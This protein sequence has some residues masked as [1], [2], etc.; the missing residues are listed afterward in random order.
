MILSLSLIAA[1]MGGV[2]AWVH[3]LTA[4]PI[5]DAALKAKTD[6]LESVLPEFDNNPLTEAKEVTVDGDSAP[7]T[8]YMAS[9]EGAPSGYAVESYTMDGFSGEIRVMVGFDKAGAVTGFQ[10]LQHAETPGLGAKA[11][12]WFRDPTGHR[13]IIGT[14]APLSVTKDGGDIDGI[15]AATITSRAFL[16]AVNRARKAINK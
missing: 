14:T 15:T 5:A 16:D 1:A 12:D 2:L 8:V 4:A 6:A 3:D 13:S 10:V 7:V 9:L 11:D